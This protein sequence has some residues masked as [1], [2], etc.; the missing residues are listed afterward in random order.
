MVNRLTQIVDDWDSGAASFDRGA[1]AKAISTELPAV[2]E[3][4]VRVS[5]Y[6]WALLGPGKRESPESFASFVG[7]MPRTA[8]S[9]FALV[10]KDAELAVAALGPGAVARPVE[11][12]LEVRGLT[13]YM[14][15]KTGARYDAA[16]GAQLRPLLRATLAL[17]NA[18]AADA[19]SKLMPLG[20]TFTVWYA[21]RQS[22]FPPA[23]NL[24]SYR[25]LL[26]LLFIFALQYHDPLLA[27][28]L[29]RH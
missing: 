20:A 21:V 18:S 27:L 5:L 23:I 7:T 17:H 8:D 14:C 22:L 11:L 2:V 1:L 19:G 16:M 25:D 9:G 3:D 26:E 6:R 15:L 12:V 28:H 13:E 4:R 10:E 29:E 24:R